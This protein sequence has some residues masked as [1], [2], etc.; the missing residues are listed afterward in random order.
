MYPNQIFLGLTLYD[1]F[2]CIGIILCFFTFGR[3][4]DKR[5]IRA[6]LQNFAL[7]CG[8]LA[9]VLGFGSAVLF[10]AI[11]NIPATGR[12]E[13]ATNTGAT[14]YG[15]LIGGVAVF[16]AAY[17]GIGPYAMRR[18]GIDGYHARSFFAMASCAVPAIVIAHA[19]GRLGCLTAGCC[20]GAP[21]DAWFGILMHGDM[22][23]IKYVPTQLFEAIFLFILFGVLYLNAK[24]GKRYNLPFYM[25]TYG[26]WRFII[27]FLRG[28]YRGSV[29]LPIT[30]SQLIA[31]LMVLGALGVFFLEKKITDRLEAEEKEIVDLD[32][33]CEESDGDESAEL[34]E[35][36]DE[37]VG[38]GSE[39]PEI[40]EKCDE[41]AEN[42][43]EIAEKS[44]KDE[45]N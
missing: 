7:L 5:K 18:A 32:D 16:L 4:A 42:S 21:T 40:S 2:I 27:E 35:E 17:F 31:L 13:I 29:G 28:D 43:G 39:A 34:G 22:G 3:L 8:A 14:F 26:V 37:A 12:F 30:P 20:H 6:R 38:D 9:I 23:Y 41:S 25:A 36:I 1:I 10:Q 11:Y 33:D 44:E 24:E 45:E 19:F 15:G